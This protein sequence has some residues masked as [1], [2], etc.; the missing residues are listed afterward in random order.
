[1]RQL[2]N[3]SAAIVKH[4]ILGTYFRLRACCGAAQALKRKARLGRFRVKWYFRDGEAPDMLRNALK[5]LLVLLCLAA[6]PLHG[7]RRF[8]LVIDAGH[9][10]R[11]VGALGGF[12][13]EK[14][15]NLRVALAFGA[16]VEQNC[17]DVRVV[18]TR[19]TDVFVPLQERAD[20]AN[21]AGADLFISIHTNSTADGHPAY[22]SE[23]YTL[24][25][26]RAGANL[27]VAQRE[28]SV[29]TYEKG[30]QAK[31]EAYDPGKAESSIMFEYLQGKNMKQSVE[32][33]RY[34]QKE[35][36]RGGRPDKGV[37]QANLLVLR[38]TSM[39]AVLTELGFI[40]TPS[41][42]EYLNS[43]AG[44]QVL[45]TSI[46]NGFLRYLRQ[47]GGKHIAVPK[48]LDAKKAAHDAT[49]RFDK[50]DGEAEVVPVATHLDKRA[51]RKPAKEAEKPA[52]QPAKPVKKEET[53]AAKPEKP[54]SKAEKPAAQPAKPVKKEE[55]PAA[56]PAKPVK[57]EEKPAAQPAKPAAEPAKPAAEKKVATP[58]Q[59]KATEKKPSKPAAKP[60]APAAEKSAAA[61]AKGKAEAKASA[62]AAAYAIQVAAMKGRL[63]PG[64]PFFHGQAATEVQRGGMYVY[65]V[66]GYA[67]RAEAQRALPEMQKLFPGA[68][69]VKQSA[70]QSTT[71]APAAAKSDAKPAAKD[72]AQTKSAPAATKSNTQPAAKDKSQT[73][74][75]A[76]AAKSNTKPAAKDKS[77]TKAA[78]PAGKAGAKTA[79]KDKAQTKSAPAAGKTAQGVTTYRIQLATTP[80]A[81]GNGEARLKNVKGVT[82]RKAGKGYAHMTGEYKTRAEA[83]RALAGLKKQFPDAYIVTYVDGKRK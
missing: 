31:V 29:V 15:I 56:Q 77:Q 60:A 28:N 34:L 13:Q 82:A 54:V 20:V 47:Y 1:M 61:P 75:A 41:E 6:L 26:A 66:G 65:T 33:A 11:D 52:A 63:K 22:G 25:L 10:G 39:P 78:A 68:F 32:M 19:R 57:K 5:Y 71:N 12:S 67:T 7:A 8:V 59:K 83:Q 74:A 27:A 73:K 3:N 49:I 23:T 58:T 16:L 43:E 69:V 40:N 4:K 50:D 62:P 80:T 53:P 35:Y 76:P 9:G 72:K 42:E 81:D 44:T 46:Y 14:D 51:A 24:T 30:D 2:P 17:R 79:T 70:S 21:K 36:A 64:D 55:K 38:N 45:A 48:A 18:Y 37:K